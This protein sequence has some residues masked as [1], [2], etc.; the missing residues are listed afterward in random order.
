MMV[1]PQRGSTR[2]SALRTFLH[3]CFFG[4]S[5][6]RFPRKGSTTNP[7]SMDAYSQL[8]LKLNDISQRFAHETRLLCVRDR[9]R[10][11]ES[12]CVDV[13]L[14][15]CVCVCRVCGCACVRVCASMCA[16]VYVCACVCACMR[17]CVRVYVCVCVRA[18]VCVFVCEHLR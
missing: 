9:E 12:V 10:E 5:I 7:S 14:C 6:P 13:R 18:C 17:E 1:V 8:Q 11:R 4:A 15:V 16:C 3:L 2:A